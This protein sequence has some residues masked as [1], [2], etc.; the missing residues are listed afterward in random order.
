MLAE[1]LRKKIENINIRILL[2]DP[3]L[4]DYFRKP[5]L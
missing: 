1:K 2:E 4:I 5:T 3:Q